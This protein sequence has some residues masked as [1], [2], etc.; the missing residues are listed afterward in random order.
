MGFRLPLLM[1][2]R[3]PE[4]GFALCGKHWRCKRQPENA[5]VVKSIGSLWS[6]GGSPTFCLTTRAM[7]LTVPLGDKLWLYYVFSKDF[8]AAL[9]WNTKAA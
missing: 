7:L 9:G 3:Q 4:N 2:Q 8:Q 6:V 1:M 5:V